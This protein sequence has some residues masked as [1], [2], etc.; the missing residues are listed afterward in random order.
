[1]KNFLKNILIIILIFLI[2]IN[3]QKLLDGIINA[4]ILF[5]NKIFPSIFPILIVSDLI[6]SSNI[7]NIISIL[8]GP[9]FNKAFKISPKSA[10][11]YILSMFTG[12]PSSA[13]YIKDLLDNKIITKKE[14]EK[15]LSSSLLYNPILIYNITFFL[16][17]KD[18]IFLII[19]NIISNIL[20]G[21]INRNKNIDIIDNNISTSSFNLINSIS[22]S[23]N[24]L[25]LIYGSIITFSALSNIIPIKHPLLSGILEITNGINMINNYNIIYDY[26]L[27]WS[28]ILLS[29]GGLSIIY[30]IKSIFKND[31][32]D[33]SLFYKSRIIHLI[34][35]IILTKIRIYL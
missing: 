3:Y 13:K 9:L 7:I 18:R 5:I 21:L 4:S 22:K 34:M 26:K 1:M 10:Y 11:V 29:F 27:L 14:A 31:A 8:F 6:T 25:L 15:I 33:Y 28:S 19:I 24:T 12:S 30:Q 17:K 32:L 35:M 16:E 23:I 2:F 20:I